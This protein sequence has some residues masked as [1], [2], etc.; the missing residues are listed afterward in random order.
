LKARF[1]TDARKA[2]ISAGV[3]NYFVSEHIFKFK[4]FFTIDADAIRDLPPT[5]RRNAVESW[6]VGLIFNPSTL[7]FFAKRHTT[8]ARFLGL[9]LLHSPKSA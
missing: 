9:L 5:L 1:S 7:R 2:S 3:A 4:Q 6:V 8:Q